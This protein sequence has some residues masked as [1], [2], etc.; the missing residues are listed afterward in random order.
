MIVTAWEASARPVPP[1]HESKPV[2]RSTA[3]RNSQY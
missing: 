2:P 3:P 1:W